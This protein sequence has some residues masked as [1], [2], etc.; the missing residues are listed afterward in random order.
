MSPNTPY[1]TVILQTPPFHIAYLQPLT[2]LLYFSD[3]SL[4]HISNYSHPTGHNRPIPPSHTAYLQP[5]SRPYAVQYIPTPSS[6]MLYSIYQPLPPICCTVYTNPSLLCCTVQ[7]ITTPSTYVV[8]YICTILFLLSYTVQYIPTPSSYY[9][10]YQP[11][12]PM[13]YTVRTVYTNPSSYA[14]QYSI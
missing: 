9:S 12:P 5:H 10:K 13:L 2:P 7:Y 3:P 6:Y 8:Q 11:L 4:L 1:P 14:V